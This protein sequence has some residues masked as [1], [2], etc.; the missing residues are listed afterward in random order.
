MEEIKTPRYAFIPVYLSHCNFT[1]A[2][3]KPR[4]KFELAL[5]ENTHMTMRR[6]VIREVGN[7]VSTFLR[8]I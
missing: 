3:Q 1:L 4:K 2:F 8:G 6:L 7:R 5:H